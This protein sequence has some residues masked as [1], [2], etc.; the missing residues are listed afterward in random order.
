MSI[1]QGS[2]FCRAVPNLR[3]TIRSKCLQ[4]DLRQEWLAALAYE[5]AAQAPAVAHLMG[6]RHR[7]QVADVVN[8]ALLRLGTPPTQPPP[9]C[10]ALE[11]LLRQAAVCHRELRE[12]NGG[13]GELFHLHKAIALD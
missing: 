13:Q 7:E 6:Q 9:L 2:S 4:I 12:A 10:S 3:V 5:D 8:A 11:R 1:V